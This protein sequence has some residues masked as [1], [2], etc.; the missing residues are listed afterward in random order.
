MMCELNREASRAIHNQRQ[1]LSEAIVRRQYEL[2]PEI[3][4]P[5]GEIGREKSVRDAGYHLSYLSEAMAASDPALFADYVAW[6]KVLFAGLSFPDQVLPMTLQCVLDVLQEM[7]PEE[8]KAIANE[9]LEA[10]LRQLSQAPSVL[11]TFLSQD[12]PWAGLATTYLDALLRGERH[13]ASHLILDAVDR[14]VPIKD[15]YLHVFQPSQHEIGRLWQMNQISVAQEHYCTAATQLI[16]SQLYP[17]IFATE[18]I[19]RRLVATC[20]GGELHEIG[21]RMVADFFEME[22]WDTYYL[23]ANTPTESIV[24]TVLERSADI[25]GVSATI[26]FHASA[27]VDLIAHM[28]ASEAGDVKIL[29]GGYPFNVALDL[30]RQVGADG[31]AHDAQEAVELANRLVVDGAEG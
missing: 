18:R 30:W 29:V 11:P 7:L 26:A 22:G 5:Y 1:M 31:C 14:G 23:G 12:A 10:G 15:L 6:V 25:L 2:Q 3:W 17:R 9:Y 21:I 19:G 4:Q 27:V 13:V 28:R 16:M 20:V 24:Q 8:L